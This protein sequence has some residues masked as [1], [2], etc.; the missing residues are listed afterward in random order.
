[1]QDDLPHAQWRK[2]TYSGNTGNC[3][4]AA[5]SDSVVG[6]RDSITASMPHPTS[7]FLTQYRLSDGHAWADRDARRTVL[8]VSCRPGRRGR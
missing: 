5:I 6:V 1:M 3:L 8:L 4:E 7:R 2:S